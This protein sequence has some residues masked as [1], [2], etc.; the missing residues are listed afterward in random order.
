MNR[1]GPPRSPTLCGMAVKPYFPALCHSSCRE[2]INAGMVQSGL[3]GQGTFGIVVKAL[4]LRCEPPQ[5][6][7]I[8]LLPRGDI[9][10][11]LAILF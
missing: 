4:D 11:P 10:G 3:L 6:V 1:Q 5:E 9:V 2:V 7:A 8:K